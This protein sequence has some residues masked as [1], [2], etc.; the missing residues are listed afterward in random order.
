[1]QLKENNSLPKAPPRQFVS[2]LNSKD[3]ALQP[4]NSGKK[5]DGS[6]RGLL[7][8]TGGVSVCLC[9]FPNVIIMMYDDLAP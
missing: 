2:V 3:Q 8:E 6:C 4:H 7:S 9:V 1:M 5:Y